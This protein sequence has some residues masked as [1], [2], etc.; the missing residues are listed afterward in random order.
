MLDS[1]D[2]ASGTIVVGDER[3]EV[4]REI[5]SGGG[6]VLRHAIRMLARVAV[7]TIDHAV[8]RHDNFRRSGVRRFLGKA[9]Y[10]EPIWDRGAGSTKV[11]AGRR[12]TLG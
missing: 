11:Q 9:S 12:Q 2:I 6:T 4:G 10:G 5:G 8:I 3:V 7:E 1:R